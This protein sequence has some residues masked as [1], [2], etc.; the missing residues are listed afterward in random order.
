MLARALSYVDWAAASMLRPGFFAFVHAPQESSTCWGLRR[1]RFS[2]SEVVLAKD[3]LLMPTAIHSSPW[4]WA[5]T[6]V[7]GPKCSKVHSLSATPLKSPYAR[8][9]V[10]PLA[11]PGRCNFTT[12]FEQ[13]LQTY[14]DR[15]SATYLPHMEREESINTNPF[16]NLNR[17][18][19]MGY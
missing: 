17:S 3:Y 15:V 11:E 16:P 5:V 9:Q 19:F 14:V 12:S 1:V 18:G 13:V 4:S 8:S 7:V 10:H 2:V 6:R